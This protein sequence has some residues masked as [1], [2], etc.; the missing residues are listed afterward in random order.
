[1]K[2]LYKILVDGKSCH[3]GDLKWS[4]PKNG[5]PGK[6]HKVKGDLTI[7]EK[8]IHLTTKPF[9]W[10]KWGC[11]CYEAE[12]KGISD[13]QDYKCVCS[14]ARLLK[15][16]KYPK[17]WTDTENWV[18]TLKDISWLKPDGK[19]KKE[20]MLFETRDAARDAAWDAARDAARNA[21]RDAARNAARN[22][23]WDAAWDAARDAA[24]DAAGDAA[25]DAA[26][27]AAWN[28]AWDAAGDAARDAAWDAALYSRGLVV[29]DLNLAEK[30]IVHIKKRMEVWQKGYGL[31]CDVNGKLYVYKKI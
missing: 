21:A 15:V 7:C 29:S 31:F 12:A 19:P 26:R 14:E 9:M 8:G 16:K 4:L 5:K 13:W 28:A 24:R 11:T 25:R 6:W 23:A 22:A 27:N 10:Y 20:W 17:W 30:Y 2:K 3:G 18:K 1:M